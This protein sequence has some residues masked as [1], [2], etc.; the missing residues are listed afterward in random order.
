[1]YEG[2]VS[3]DL[4]SATRLAPA[5]YC[6]GF[7]AV[8]KY[9]K[10][11]DVYE[12]SIYYEPKAVASVSTMVNQVAL[13]VGDVQRINFS[14]Y[15]P[16][17]YGVMKVVKVGNIATSLPG[18][19]LKCSVESWDASIITCEALIDT[20]TATPGLVRVN[21]DVNTTH[22]R[23]NQSVDTTHTLS[24]NVKAALP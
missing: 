21:I 19:T 24:L 10:M 2:E 5:L 17:R 11:S 8:S 12:K 22:V 7:A 13:T 18:S 20:R 15:D 1:V 6:V 4:Y 3:I 16:T 23:S 9:G 14:I